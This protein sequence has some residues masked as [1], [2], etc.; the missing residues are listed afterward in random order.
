MFLLNSVSKLLNSIQQS[1]TL[2]MREGIIKM[3]VAHGIY[4]SSTAADIKY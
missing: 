2:G 4:E 3:F 1:C